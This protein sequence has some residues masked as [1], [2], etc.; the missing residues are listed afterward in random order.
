VA[1][2]LTRVAQCYLTKMRLERAIAIYKRVIPW[3]ADDFFVITWHP[4]TLDPTLPEE[5]VDTKIHL[6]KKFGKERVAF[7]T[8]LLGVA[9]E[10]EGVNFTL[11]GKIGPTRNAHRLI[12]L[13]KTKD[14]P[15]IENKLVTELFKAHFEDGHDI[16]SDEML[17]SAG[18]KAGLYGNEIRQ[19]LDTGGGGEEVDRGFN[20]AVVRGIRAVPDIVINEDYKLAGVQ[21]TITFLEIFLRVKKSGGDVSSIQGLTEV[22]R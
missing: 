17:V 22:N 2:I 3:A 19:W 8:A 21:D 20:D 12:Q 11:A 18:E 15:D 1:A 9:G 16:T 7:A 10:G 6:E 13:A 14:E 4:F 5:G